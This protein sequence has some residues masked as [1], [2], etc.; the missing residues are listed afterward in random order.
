MGVVGSKWY[1]YEVG[2]KWY[3]YELAFKVLI[4]DRY[5]GL[6]IIDGGT[7]ISTINEDLKYISC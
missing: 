2:N 7:L 4:M 3:K 1:K 5:K 6:L